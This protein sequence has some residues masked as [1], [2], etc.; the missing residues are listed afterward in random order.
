MFRTDRGVKL[1]ISRFSSGIF[2][3]ILLLCT[4]FISACQSFQVAKVITPQQ[5][6]AV[7]ND[8]NDDSDAINKALLAL[9]NGDTLFFPAGIYDLDQSIRRDGLNNITIAGESGSM[10]RKSSRFKGEYIFYIRFSNHVTVEGLSFEGLT[11]DTDLVR[12]GEQGLFMGSTRDSR[13]RNNTFRNFGDACL[14]VTTSSSDPLKGVNSHNIMVEHNRFINCT[15]VTTTQVV[16]GY[17]GTENITAQWNYFDGLKG[18]LKLCSR[19]PVSNGKVLNNIFAS[20]KGNAIEVCSYSNI[21]VA[22]NYIIDNQKYA[23]NYYENRPFPWDNHW[24]HNNVIDGSLAGIGFWGL[25]LNSDYGAIKNVNIENNCFANIQ[26]GANLHPGV[27]RLTSNHPTDS[28]DVVQVVKNRFYNVAGNQLLYIHP[29]ALNVFTDDNM[30]I[31]Y[32]CKPPTLAM[33][34]KPNYWLKHHTTS[35][36]QKH[37]LKLIDQLND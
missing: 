5:Y 28:Y 30:L 18:S 8:N 23:I 17:G 25:Q 14:R 16:E 19:E 12:W 10:L 7:V 20:G 29:T 4:G 13:I 33:L 26:G 1:P 15:Q 11:Q 35:T 37:W 34:A 27:V 3:T 36:Y 6:G 32:N 24:I 31:P 2:V 21:E 9:K 22:G